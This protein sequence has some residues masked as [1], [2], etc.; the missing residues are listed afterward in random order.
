MKNKRLS[1]VIIFCLFSSLFTQSKT[2]EFKTVNVTLS[3]IPVLTE[4]Q[5]RNPMFKE[6][7]YIVSDNYKL[8]AGEKEPDMIFFKYKVTEDFNI[9]QL[10][11]RCNIPYDTIASLNSLENTDDSIKGKTL[12]LPTVP[13]LFI[14]KNKGITALEILL[15]EDYFNELNPEKC[16]CYVINGKSYI[17][18]PDKRFSPTERAFF[19]DAGFRLPLD[20]NSFWISSDFG[21]RKQPF[22]G[23]WKKHN[24][25]DFAAN[26]GTKVYAVKNG[27]VIAAVKNDPTFGNY[28]I[29]SHDNGKVSSVYAHL[30]KMNV[31]LSDEVKKG[32]VIG[33]VGQTGMATGPHLHFEIRQGGVPQDPSIKL[34]L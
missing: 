7:S 30:S 14:T 11:S 18:L 31:Q 4:L 9:L 8:M 3:H 1:A 16:I 2:K 6:Y 5:S 34:K 25:I 28:I 20:R 24:G 10:A 19:L 26:T 32:D 27:R 15:R 21:N 33:Y 29:I 13:G 22:T 23:E 17:F 12:I